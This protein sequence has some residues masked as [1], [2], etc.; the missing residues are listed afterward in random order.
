MV[1]KNKLFDSQVVEEGNRKN[2]DTASY[3]LTGL[4]AAATAAIITYNVFAPTQ[5]FFNNDGIIKKAAK[6]MGLSQTKD[7]TAVTYT[8]PKFLSCDEGTIDTLLLKKN[9][10]VNV[11][12]A[13]RSA[14]NSTTNVDP[15]NSVSEQTPG[16]RSNK[17]NYS[18][19]KIGC[20]NGS[21]AEDPF[22]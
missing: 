9:N 22:K 7:S 8:A 21:W 3:I 14:N 11:N 20:D 6:Y 4:A 15:G 18:T 13:K 12:V 17:S 1:K 5:Y 16:N 10:F 19:G 2:R